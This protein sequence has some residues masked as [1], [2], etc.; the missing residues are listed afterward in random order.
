MSDNDNQ[1]E[2]EFAQL[3]DRIKQN[4]I[5]AAELIDE[6]DAMISGYV[7]EAEERD[8]DWGVEIDSDGNVPLALYHFDLR[9]ATSPLMRAISNA[10][11]SSSSLRC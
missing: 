9:E 4:M 11:W 1:L 10:G 6:C 5:K 7:V 8:K 3:Q 2:A